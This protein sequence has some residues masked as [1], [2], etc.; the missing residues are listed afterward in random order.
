MR[1]HFEHG[2]LTTFNYVNLQLYNG[3]EEARQEARRATCTETICEQSPTAMP[4]HT[5]VQS[6]LAGAFTKY[7]YTVT[8][9]Q[10]FISSKA[11]N[12]AYLRLL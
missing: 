1:G 9:T 4:N 8:V 10:T 7:I 12:S 2:P 3:L 11:I 5:W 6:Q